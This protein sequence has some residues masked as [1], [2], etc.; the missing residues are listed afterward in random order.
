[1]SEVGRDADLLLTTDEQDSQEESAMNV[2]AI[3]TGTVAVKSRQ[4]AGVGHGR[5]RF[6]RTL[7]DG[8]WTEPLPILTWVIDHAEGLIVVDTGET[9]RVGEPGYFPRWHPYFHFGLREWVNRPDEIGAQLKTHGITSRDVRLVV[10]T[11]LHTDH[12]GGLHDF[13]HSEILVS[14]REMQLASGFAG[15]MRGYLNNRFPD[16]FSPRLVHFDE[17][18]LGPFPVS[19]SLTSSGDIRVVPTPGHTPGHVSVAVM[20]NDCLLFLAGD[21]S[22]TEDLMLRG[23]VDGVATSDDDARL[24]LDRIRALTTE[25][26]VVYLPSHDPGSVERLTGRR[27]TRDAVRAP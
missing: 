8:E 14:Q 11:H 5:A 21:A 10:L 9:S 2:L 1:L 18:P 19:A 23:V 24:T 25:E 26:R 22:Y 15:R 20:A 13:P 17:E 6:V 7:A 3:Q 4:R 12:A 16:W 27:R